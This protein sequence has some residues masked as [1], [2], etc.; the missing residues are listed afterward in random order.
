MFLITDSIFFGTY[1]FVNTRFKKK[2]LN[3]MVDLLEKSQRLHHV[4]SRP[5]TFLGWQET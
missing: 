2:S 3:Q 4:L 5:V 1:D